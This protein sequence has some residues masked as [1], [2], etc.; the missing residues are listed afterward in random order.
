[1]PVL[2]DF[3]GAELPEGR[4][5]CPRCG[6][7]VPNTQ[8]HFP[9][10]CVNSS[11]RPPNELFYT[12]D[13]TPP[14]SVWGFFWSDILLCLPIIGVIVQIIW[15]FGGT[16][17]R[18]RRHF[19]VA[20]LIRTIIGTIIFIL[21]IRFFSHEFRALINNLLIHLSQALS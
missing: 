15:A 5:T 8:P 1:M 17:N 19:A 6:T 14:L 20:R 9:R 3:C 16:R 4:I 12:C 13:E 18:N 21:S 7:P 2:C 11:S 10:Q